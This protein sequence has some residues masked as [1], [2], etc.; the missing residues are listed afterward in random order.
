MELFTSSTKSK[1]SAWSFSFDA[2]M[3]EGSVRLAAYQGKA[4]LIVNT[5]SK[6]G[7]TDQYKGLELLYQKYRESGLVVIGVPS[8]DFGSQEPGTHAEIARFCESNYGVSFPMTAKYNVKGENA[9][10]FYKWAKQE[11]GFGTAPKWNFHKYLID[12]NGMLVDYFHS[13]TQLNADRMISAVEL[14]LGTQG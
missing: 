14:V 6:C 4:I 10:A 3:S 11:L 2:L 1:E 13:P 5:A 9:H 8:N 7:L 12:R